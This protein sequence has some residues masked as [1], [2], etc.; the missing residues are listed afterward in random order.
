MPRLLFALIAFTVVT[1]TASCDKD[2]DNKDEEAILYGT[3]V[4]GPNTGDTL[5]FFKKN[6]RNLLK[7]NMS[8][9]SQM[10]SPMEREYRMVNGKPEVRFGPDFTGPFFDI[11]SFTWKIPGREFELLGFH[12]YMIMSSSITKFTFTKID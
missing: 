7:M 12:L 4:K 5:V 2:S 6:G 3:W 10:Y 1:L 11:E 9:N 8:F